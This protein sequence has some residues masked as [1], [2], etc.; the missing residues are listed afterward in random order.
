M[1]I[2]IVTK[3]GRV[4]AYETAQSAGFDLTAYLPDGDFVL[5]AGERALIPTGT[6]IELPDG[7]EA[8]VR[9]RSGLSIKHGIGMTNGI[10]TIDPD[11]RGE[12][13]VPMI[14]WSGEDYT[15]R[16]GDRIA[17][18]IINKFERVGFDVVDE[19]SETERGAGGFGSTGR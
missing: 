1:D 12:L 10:G 7:Y 4:P 13:R 9:S 5:K 11:Y 17:Q 15:V 19:L 16:D 8:Q 14:N 3:S 18:V 6:Y 2:K